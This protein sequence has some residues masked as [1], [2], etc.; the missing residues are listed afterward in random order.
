MGNTCAGKC[1]TDEMKLQLPCGS[2][3]CLHSSCGCFGKK[4]GD[5]NRKLKAAIRVEMALIEKQLIEQ[6]KEAFKANKQPTFRLISE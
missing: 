6:M 1:E 2:F 3:G 4:D 5:E